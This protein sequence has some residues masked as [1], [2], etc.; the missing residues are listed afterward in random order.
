MGVDEGIQ[1][2]VEIC[3]HYGVQ[4]LVEDDEGYLESAVKDG[5]VGLLLKEGLKTT[6]KAEG[7]RTCCSWAEVTNWLDVHEPKRRLPALALW[8]RFWDTLCSL[9]PKCEACPGTI[10]TELV[11]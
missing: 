1:S 2:K 8:D 9:L 7:T 6:I 3:R 4:V 11:E 5:V 10:T